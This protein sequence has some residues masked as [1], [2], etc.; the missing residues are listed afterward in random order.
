M[1]IQNVAIGTS[2][3][4]A[5]TTGS[6][7]KAFGYESLLNNVDGMHNIAIGDSALRGNT[8]DDYNIAIG[9]SALNSI[10]GVGNGSNIAIGDSCLSTIT[11]GHDN[12]VLG[13]NI[14]GSTACSQ[15]ILI[16]NYVAQY[17]TTAGMTGSVIIGYGAGINTSGNTNTF[18]GAS[19]GS[20]TTTGAGNICIGY[21]ATASSAIMNNECTIYVGS[22]TARFATGSASWTFSSDSRDKTDIEQITVGLDFINQIK[23]SVYRWDKREWYESGVSDGSKKNEKL[24][25]G[26]IAQQLDEVQTA[27][28][29]EYLNLVYKPNPDKIE[30]AQTNLIPVMVKALQD[31]SK[32]NNELRARIEALEQKVNS[33]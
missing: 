32:E 4:Q 7:N 22:T 19:A 27:N 14:L 30:I 18:I 26:F 15:N 21:N 12:I 28:N 2:A 25:T 3:L 11:S 9:F 33:L 13:T 5:N 8:S 23:P 1:G 16:G 20:S 17:G 29:A 10:N 31:L 24:H 6:N